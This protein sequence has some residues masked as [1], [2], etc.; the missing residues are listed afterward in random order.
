MDNVGGSLNFGNVGNLWYC[1][2]NFGLDFGGMDIVKNLCCRFVW[3][4]SWCT[5]EILLVCVNFISWTWQN[6]VG[7]NMENLWVYGRILWAWNFG[8][9]NIFVGYVMLNHGKKICGY[10]FGHVGIFLLWFWRCR[11]FLWA[12]WTCRKNFDDYFGH[13]GK[14]L[15]VILDM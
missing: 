13:V 4:Y 7:M 8:Y 6:F 1:W 12:F 2:V 10:D 3:I 14:S 9:G 5:W 11:N 15:M